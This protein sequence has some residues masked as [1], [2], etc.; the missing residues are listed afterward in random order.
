[1]EKKQEKEEKQEEQGL[2][3][4]FSVFRANWQNYDRKFQDKLVPE[5]FKEINF[6]Q[7]IR[8]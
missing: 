1:M 4:L 3:F 2:I 6:L 5:S 8:P 7:S